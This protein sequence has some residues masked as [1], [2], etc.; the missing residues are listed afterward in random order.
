MADFAARLRELRK[1]KKL[2]QADLAAGIGVAQTTIANYEQHSRFP[3]E[4]TL[5]RLADY[6]DTSLDYLLGRSELPFPPDQIVEYHKRNAPG[7]ES[8]SPD[9]MQYLN[10]LLYGDKERAFAQVISRVRNGMTVQEV[11][12]TVLEP[13]LKEVGRLWETNEVDVSQEHYFSH[14]TESLMGQLRAYLRVGDTAR[15]TVVLVAVGGELHEIGIRMVSDFLEAAGYHCLYLGINTPTTSIVKAIQ[16]SEADV[17]AISATLALNTDAVANMIGNVR[18]ATRR[19]GTKDLKVIT[20]GSA[21]N[22]DQ[23]LWRQ[24]GADG[25]A[26]CADEA[27][28]LVSRLLGQEQG[29]E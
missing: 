15:G 4:G 26:P 19:T 8:L 7:P 2:R 18:S 25:Y 13:S 3:D 10:E 17:L 21:F 16:D 27:V 22:M 12:R 5:R 9:A 6:L 11:Y 24:V 14:A 29:S 28:R 23:T 20:G 1:A